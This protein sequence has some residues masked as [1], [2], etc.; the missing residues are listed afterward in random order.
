VRNAFTTG[1]LGVLLLGLGACHD[2]SALEQQLADLRT[3]QSRVQAV[4]ANQNIQMEDMQNRMLLLSD[5]M[6][7]NRI[8][9]QRLGGTGG[10][11]EGAG[12]M[13]R[14]LGADSPRDLPVVRLSPREPEPEAADEEP[15]ALQQLDSGGNLIQM[16]DPG[17]PP[18]AGVRANQGVAPP[19]P[20]APMQQ[21][22]SSGRGF[23]SRPVMMYNQGMELLKAKNH[24]QAIMVF[25]NFL[26]QWP[27]HEYADNCMYW[28]GEALYDQGKYEQALA[29]FEGVA[30]RYPDGNKVPD[31]LLKAAF[32]Y[33]KLGA[34]DRA[35]E[36]LDRVLRIY[37]GTE[38][39][40]I[41]GRSRG[42]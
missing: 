23:D 18:P 6:D 20:Q 19:A 31:A 10:I 22:V 12:P 21:K 29:S 15:V 26:N 7:S 4:Q 30:Q 8:M 41:A 2:H 25:E 24:Q 5:E 13:E 42:Q 32:C 9:I 16:W 28:I 17:Q 33:D 11:D 40:R 37:P 27:G 36:L 1:L 34:P 14:L 39:A 3:D 35:R 38:A